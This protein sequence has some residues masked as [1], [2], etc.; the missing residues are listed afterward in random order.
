MRSHQKRTST[1]AGKT[2]T[3]VRSRIESGGERVWRL[4]D[5][6]GMSGMAVAQT[7]SRLTRQGIIQRLGKGLYYRPRQTAFGLS[8]P[9]AAR[10]RALPG[11]NRTFPAGTAAA[12][13]LGF[14]TLNPA[15]VEVATDGLSLPRLIVGKDT[16]IHTRRPASWRELS[17]TDAAILDFLR[18]RGKA[19]ELPAEETVD[20]LLAYCRQPGRFARLLKVAASEPPRVRAMLGAIG[21]QLG[22]QAGRLSILRRGLNPLSRFDF[23]ALGA[24]AHAK[25]WQAKERENHETL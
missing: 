13:L 24:L 12:N 6:A 23:G 22:Q 2:A 1:P 5:F 11:R 9:N 17:E 18:N 21:Q 19:S 14:T 15:R 10:I 8:R 4:A 3:I 16:V 25:E 20:K 7:L